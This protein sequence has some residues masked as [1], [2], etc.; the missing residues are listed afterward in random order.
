MPLKTVNNFDYM[1]FPKEK[2]LN[3]LGL[4][5]FEKKAFAAID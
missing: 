2:A 5:G 3:A 1:I 4:T